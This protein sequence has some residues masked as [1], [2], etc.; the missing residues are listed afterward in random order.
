[1]PSY[2]HLSIKAELRSRINILRANTFD[3]AINACKVDMINSGISLNLKCLHVE[4]SKDCDHS[5]NRNNNCA[6]RDDKVN[7]EENINNQN[8]SE[9]H[10][11]RDKCLNTNVK[12]NHNENLR[13]SS[14]EKSASSRII[15][16]N[17]RV[18]SRACDIEN[19]KNKHSMDTDKSLKH[20][21]GAMSTKDSSFVDECNSNIQDINSNNCLN[22]NVALEQSQNKHFKRKAKRYIKKAKPCGSNGNLTTT[23]I[24]LSE[25]LQNVS[26]LPKQ[27]CSSTENLN[28]SVHLEEKRA[29]EA[30]ELSK[31]NAFISNINEFEKGTKKRKLSHCSIPK[32]FFIISDVHQIV[33]FATHLLVTEIQSGKWSYHGKFPYFGEYDKDVYSSERYLNGVSLY[34]KVACD[35]DE[36]SLQKCNQIAWSS[37]NTMQSCHIAAE[38]I[39]KFATDIIVPSFESAGV[40]KVAMSNTSK[41]WDHRVFVATMLSLRELLTV[42][43]EKIFFGNCKF[44]L[45]HSD[46]NHLQLDPGEK[47][48]QLNL[49]KEERA[50]CSII[51]SSAVI[52]STCKRAR[53]TYDTILEEVLDAMAR[54]DANHEDFISCLKKADGCTLGV[55][56]NGNVLGKEENIA[57]RVSFNTCFAEHPLNLAHQRQHALSKISKVPKIGNDNLQNQIIVP[58][59]NACHLSVIDM[60][61]FATLDEQNY[62]SR[63]DE[64]EKVQNEEM[65]SFMN[66]MENI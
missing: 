26:T 33:M 20:K 42:N 43:A 36:N 50:L 46:K 64:R 30:K 61:S 45:L 10:T 23:K 47:K 49:Y 51:V 8:I 39:E 65:Q 53:N 37:C 13:R 22:N 58:L 7:K 3:S 32:S 1:M 63:N 35:K 6:D 54:Y 62:K 52:I 56:P 55:N 24:I 29:G 34:Q 60:N 9:G 12:Y 28:K 16:I 38:A 31:E 5:N 14:L 19:K 59:P 15:M 2:S 41:L 40:G 11:T 17:D 27:Y 25:A 48:R 66:M 57:Y 21:W 18:S 44:S 4:G